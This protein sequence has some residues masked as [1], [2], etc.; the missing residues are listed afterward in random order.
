MANESLQSEEQPQFIPTEKK[1][2]F[3]ETE[4]RVKPE[5]RTEARFSL[6]RENNNNSKNQEK[7]QEKGEKPVDKITELI[8]IAET[9]EN[10]N[11]FSQNRIERVTELLLDYI[12]TY[13]HD[14]FLMEEFNEHRIVIHSTS[15]LKKRAFNIQNG[16]H[17]NAQSLITFLVVKVLETDSQKVDTAVFFEFMCLFDGILEHRYSGKFLRE[18]FIERFGYSKIFVFFE[19]LCKGRKRGDNLNLFLLLTLCINSEKIM[20]A[21]FNNEFKMLIKFAI[22]KIYDKNIIDCTRILYIFIGNGA[23]ILEKHYET[24]IIF[25]SEFFVSPINF[26]G[27]SI[28]NFLIFLST[29]RTIIS[30]TQNSNSEQLLL[31]L[32]ESLVK[33]IN[34]LEKGNSK[35]QIKSREEILCLCGNYVFL[36]EIHKNIRNRGI[37][38]LEL[39]LESVNMKADNLIKSDSH[40]GLYVPEFVYDMNVFRENLNAKE[41]IYLSNLYF[42][43]RFSYI[44]DFL[45]TENVKSTRQIEN[46]LENLLLQDILRDGVYVNNFDFIHAV[47]LGHKFVYKYITV[48]RK[49]Y[50]EVVNAT[51]MLNIVDLDDEGLDYVDFLYNTGKFQEIYFL[52][53]ALRSRK[54]VNNV[55]NKIFWELLRPM[56]G[57]KEQRQIILGTYK[58]LNKMLTD[59]GSLLV[60]H[61]S[62]IASFRNEI[63]QREISKITFCYFYLI[64]NNSKTRLKI[65]D[66][67]IDINEVVNDMLNENPMLFI[68]EQPQS[69]SIQNHEGKFI[70]YQFYIFILGLLLKFLINK[71]MELTGVNFYHHTFISLILGVDFEIDFFQSRPGLAYEMFLYIAKSDE[72]NG[73]EI[74]CTI[75]RGCENCMKIVIAIKKF[76]EVSID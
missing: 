13:E 43:Y 45:R 15:D 44:F 54:T 29:T 19:N 21:G 74:K 58:I 16:Y 61:E 60:G 20:C 37:K 68:C 40:S 42:K 76:Y 59:K 22:N 34:I 53:V 47:G 73:K 8:K 30:K 32:H 35:N 25:Y 57:K 33:S 10:N 9:I 5:T 64:I 28:S 14:R 38:G 70:Q 67:I 18:I 7:N 72:I 56:N 31:N 2:Q 24:L 55:K 6:E 66:L 65:L 39:N 27:M 50:Y 41:Q 11:N 4:T 48:F 46:I 49:E 23:K 1:P 52:A 71:K 36:Y 26:S 75:N 3:I 12:S 17:V 62:L 51:L 63:N 69:I